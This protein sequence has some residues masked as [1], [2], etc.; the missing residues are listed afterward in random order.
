MQEEEKILKELD[1]EKKIHNQDRLKQ[2]HAIQAQVC[3]T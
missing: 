1:Q 3:L 2:S